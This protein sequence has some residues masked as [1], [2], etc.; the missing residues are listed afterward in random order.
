MEDFLL[1]HAGKRTIQ[2][3]THLSNHSNVEFIYV[4]DEP[5]RFVREAK[6]HSW[7][8]LEKMKGARFVFSMQ[9][10]S[11][12]IRHAPALAKRVVAALKAH[13]TE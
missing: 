6:E 12:V 1:E 2:L 4:G 7:E 11:I 3:G 5:E 8:Y 9:P 13:K 10:P